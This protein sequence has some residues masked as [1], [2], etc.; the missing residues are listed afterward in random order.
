MKE[1]KKKGKKIAVYL[2]NDG[3]SSKQSYINGSKK[4]VKPVS[5]NFNNNDVGVFPKQKF[6]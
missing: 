5:N 2:L 6:F 3:K 1:A 4:R